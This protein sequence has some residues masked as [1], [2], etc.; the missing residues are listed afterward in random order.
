MTTPPSDD[1]DLRSLLRDAVSDVQPHG[2]LDQIESRSRRSTP[3]TRRWVLPTLTAA[4][5]TV[6]VIGG[7]V[8]LPGNDTS[9]DD[10]P[11]AQAPASPQGD[12]PTRAA[13]PDVTLAVPAYFVGSTAQGPR[14]Y[15]EF[16]RQPVCPGEECKLAAS[17]RT[18]VAGQ[19]DDPDYRVSWPDGTS[20]NGVTWDDELLTVDLGGADLRDRP[21]G[22]DPQE[23]ELAVQQVV[24]SAQAGLGQG[25]PPVRL[26]LEGEQADK[27]LG[28]P[29]SEPLAATSA[30]ST[31]ATIWVNGPTEGATVER[32]FE[33]SG[34][35][36]TFE[37]NVVWELKRGDEVV[38][39]GF[40][41]AQE[42]CTLSPY[43]FTVTA[44][45]GDYTLVVHDT[46][47]SDGE[48]VGTSED[49]KRITVR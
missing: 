2:T 25:R 11:A 19:P 12:S 39:S 38:E 49:T 26:L 48:G 32:R 34:Q 31:L 17:V 44:E 9:R 13:E 47:E 30:D 29:T 46:D 20:V 10:P 15:R 22:M 28:V 40:A 4:A 3:T 33:V 35:A 16:Q 6:A 23:A 14:L 7:A 42:C 27:V 41:T 18:A 8:A 5:A 24:Y 37:A 45:P 43:S 21:T 1:S 36:A